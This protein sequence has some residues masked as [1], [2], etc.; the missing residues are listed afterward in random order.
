M[1]LP[2]VE[3][4]CIWPRVLQPF[5]LRREWHARKLRTIPR[6]QCASSP[7]RRQVALPMRSCAHR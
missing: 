7:T 3:L 5:Q 4:F 2:A 1:I 6:N